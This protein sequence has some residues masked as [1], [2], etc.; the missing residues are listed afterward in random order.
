MLLIH[1][2]KLASTVLRCLQY[3]LAYH[4]SPTAVIYK[5]HNDHWPAVAFFKVRRCHEGA[6]M[7]AASPCKAVTELMHAS[8]ET[9][10]LSVCWF[11]T[12]WQHGESGASGCD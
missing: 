7:Q 9:V 10:N 1:L 11:F 12:G 5:Y 6:E 2:E 4:Y 3:T 8:H